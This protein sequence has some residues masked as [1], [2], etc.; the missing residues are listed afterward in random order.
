MD[1]KIAHERTGHATCDPRCETR[2]NVRRVSTHPRRAVAEA[3]YFDYATVK[4]NLQC[5]EVKFL[6]GARP[7]GETFA[8]VV[9]RKRTNFE[10]LDL[11]CK[12]LQTRHGHIPMYCDQEECLREVVHSSTERLGL[13]TNVP[14]I[15]QSQA[16]G[17]AEQRVRAL[18]ERLQIMFKDEKR[19]GVEI[20]LDHPV[21]Q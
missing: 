5:A 4:N 3:A 2:L 17:R 9:H 1:E 11:F 8:R 14:A 6:I 20:I 19:C 15:E 10:D 12:G 7:R 16:N 13:P 18:K 21:E